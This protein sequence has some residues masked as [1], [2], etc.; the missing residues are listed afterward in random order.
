[1]TAK[2][3]RFNVFFRRH[4][5]TCSR[6]KSSMTNWGCP[7]T[8]KNHERALCQYRPLFARL[9]EKWSPLKTWKTRSTASLENVEEQVKKMRGDC[10]MDSPT[11]EEGLQTLKKILQKPDPTR[12]RR[13]NRFC[14]QSERR[15]PPHQKQPH[16][17]QRTLFLIYQTTKGFI[18]FN[19]YRFK[20]YAVCHKY[21]EGFFN[22]PRNHITPSPF[23]EFL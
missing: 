19:I 11:S 13:K 10:H 23:W 4:A 15:N 1:L 18:Y 6:K 17:N 3:H 22:V 9:L 16:V 12:K 8:G 21:A 20:T 7:G 5:R 14:D 2:F